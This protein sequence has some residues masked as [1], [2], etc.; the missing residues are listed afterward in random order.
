MYEFDKESGELFLY[1]AIGSADWGFI[2]AATVIRDLRAISGKRATIRL[3]S[4]GGS[5]DEARAIYNAIKRHPGGVDTVV[6][7]AA[8]SAAGY[9]F[10]AGERRV[11][12]EN[13]ML[14]LHDPWTFAYGNAT[15]LRKDADV[16]DKYR[17]SIV[18]AYAGSSGKDADE[19]KAILAA[20]TWYSAAEA[21]AEGFATEVGNL[22]IGEDQWHPMAKA[23]ASI[24][25]K[26]NAE[27]GSRFVCQRPM[28]V[29]L[30]K[31]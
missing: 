12:A 8:Y 20:E 18:E 17:D 31:K 19:I 14:M 15:Q 9:I 22:V 30:Y 2:D 23:M 25:G 28:K 3:N 29:Q 1:D 6:D 24:R 13:G 11:I 7:S 4:P 21:L 5:V 10:A 16:L 27:A 26:A